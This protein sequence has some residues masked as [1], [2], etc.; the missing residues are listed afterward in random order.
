[1]EDPCYSCQR[2][3][4]EEQPSA[5]S[6]IVAISLTVT[7]FG[8]AQWFFGNLYEAVVK[9]PDLQSA[10]DRA[11]T[12]LGAGSPVRYYIA[13]IATAFPPLLAAAAT[14]WGE[15]RSRRWLGTAASCSL[16]GVGL[17]AYLVRAVNLRLFFGSQA[18]PAAEREHLLRRWYRLN[19]VR[20]V[21][22]AGALLAARQ[23]R[24]ALS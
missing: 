12:P 4:L 14:T 21:A 13:S 8:L 22:I 17:T 23:A 7:Q 24:S 1:M 5:R 15:P 9:V 18:V 16:I 10:G 19:L 6:R 3:A 2:S 20:L 11:I